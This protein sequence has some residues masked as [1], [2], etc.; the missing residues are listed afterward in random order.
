MA[1]IV[2]VEIYT[3]NSIVLLD[4]WITIMNSSFIFKQKKI[5]FLTLSFFHTVSCNDED[6]NDYDFVVI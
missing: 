1:A 5:I 6:G 4:C 3:I 2:L